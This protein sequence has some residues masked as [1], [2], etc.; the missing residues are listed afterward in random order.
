M[1]MKIKMKGLISVCLTFAL[2]STTIFTTDKMDVEATTVD[3]TELE[4]QKQETLEKIDDIKDSISAVEAYIEELEGTKQSIQTYIGELD[5]Q[6]SELESEIASL[7]LDIEE[8]Q[9]EIAT[10]QEELEEA[11]AIAEEQY[12]N[13]K[14]RMQYMYENGTTSYLVMILSADSITEVLNRVNYV[15]ELS[16]Y[17]RNMFNGYMETK[18]TIELQK[19]K[20]EIEGEELD[21]LSAAAEEQKIALENVVNSKTQEMA[22]YQAEINTESDL[23][24][25][26]ETQLEE[27]EALLT[28]I[29]N[30]IA[31]A[32][33]ANGSN[34]DGDGGASGF[35]WPCPSSS[36]IT[37][38]FG[39]R[40]SPTAGASTDHKGID[41]GASTGAAIIASAAGR[42]TT[43]T[44]SYSAGNYV[45]ISH[46]NN[47]STVYMHA[48]A[49][50][51]SVGDTVEQG[52]TI[53]AV[54]S[55]GYSTGPHLHFGIIVNGDYVDPLNYVS[56]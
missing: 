16:E 22:N 1:A 50:Y 48:S 38:Y 42:V 24:D 4:E 27:Q 34:S 41:I 52:E 31:A 10:T 47:I 44:Y 7:Q 8:K 19:A 49:L 37:S 11:E 5:T 35:I 30:Q 23:A 33:L 29:E 3:T 13:M 18:E 53:A 25:D 43:A 20:L 46:G 15:T 56:Y 6:I 32:A 14:T 9:E 28:S 39:P 26:Y 55:T 54:G 40:E 45:V 2:I 21:L 17:D 12:Q 51:V 36:R